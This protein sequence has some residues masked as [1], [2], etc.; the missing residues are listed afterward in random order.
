MLNRFLASLSVGRKFLLVLSVQSI[1]LILVTALGWMGIRASMAATGQLNWNLA[2][3]RMIERALNDSNVL[4]TVHISMIAAAGNDPYLTKR[5]PRMKEY[6]GRVEE[7]L[8]QFPTLPWSDEERPLA[9]KGM[10]SMKAYMDGFDA[11]L[12]AAK[13]RKDSA[14]PELMEGNV[15]IQRE[16]REALE[17]LQETILKSS[18]LAVRDNAL[19]GRRRQTWILGIALAG[20]LAGMGFVRMV[21]SQVTGGVK[22]LERTMSALHHGDLT[23]QSHVEGRDEL[24]H[25]S[26]SL[27]QAIVQLRDDMQT[28]AQIAEQNASSATELAATGDQISAATSEI[29]RGAEQQRTSLSRSTAAL[30]EIGRSTQAAAESAA[31]A[32]NLAKDSLD[33]SR[34]GLRS[35][36]ESTQ[37]M[38]AIRDSTQKVSRITTVIGEIAR[39]TNLLSLNAAIEAAKAGQQGKGFAV[40]AEEIRKLAERSAG[41]AKEIFGLIQ[42]S[43]QRVLAGGEAVAAVARSLEAIEQNVR[44]SAEQVHAI[45]GALEVQSRTG[46]EVVLAMS[47]TMASSSTN[48]ELRREWLTNCLPRI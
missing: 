4:R 23:V 41:A 12:A 9:M 36:G 10:A 3:S 11:L 42:E 15:Q 34:E 45:A 13:G 25:I 27:N 22:D 6:E 5:A 7:I 16:A 24:N 37:A 26:Q 35:A 29:S 20:L 17:K 31:S 48:P 32:E 43:D 8:R 21:S 14:V 18:D 47:A 30:G 19:Q 2:K 40:V 39:Q 44:R 38:A 46:G 1:L 33:A 28:M